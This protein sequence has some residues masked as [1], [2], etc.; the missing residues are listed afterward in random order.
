[1]GVGAAMAPA[2]PGGPRV[3]RSSAQPITGG[4]MRRNPLAWQP[5]RP[6]PIPGGYY[7]P[8]V[9]AEQGATERGAS[10]VTQE[11]LTGLTRNNSDYQLAKGGFERSQQEGLADIGTARAQ[12]QQD[13]QQALS[14]LSESYK[15]LAGKQEEQQNVGGV[16]QGGA[17]LQ[18]AQKRSANELKEQEPIKQTDQRNLAA[19]GLK[20][21]QLEEGTQRSLGD[22]ALHS[23][24][25]SPQVLRLVGELSNPSARANAQSQL[26][27]LESTPGNAGLFGGRTSQ[28]I[29]TKL[30]HAQREAA[31]FGVNVQAQKAR[32][33]AGFGYEPSGKPGNEYATKAKPTSRFYSTKTGPAGVATA[34]VPSQVYHTISHGNQ[35]WD[36]TPSGQVLKRRNK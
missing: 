17:A 31:Q 27:G 21:T 19:L 30:V 3:V 13:T 7:N 1:M 33:A 23:G 16:L 25:I 36:V 4:R 29:V 8:T 24:A 10:D 15:R 9:D 2:P 14:R 20:Q 28:D 35:W 11:A 32:E 26:S 18:A 6:T 5:W 22:L 34:A 12:E